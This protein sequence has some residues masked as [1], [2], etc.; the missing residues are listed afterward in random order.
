M[1]IIPI[2]PF[3][4]KYNP[5]YR[6]KYSFSIHFEQPIPNHI[7]LQRFIMSKLYFKVLYLYGLFFLNAYILSL[8]KLA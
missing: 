4:E 5:E 1:Y 7:F 3:K 8:I 6:I 2:K